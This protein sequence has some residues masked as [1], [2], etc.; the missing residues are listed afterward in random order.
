M[1]LP[2]FGKGKDVGRGAGGF[3]SELKKKMRAEFKAQREIEKAAKKAAK[4][5]RSQSEQL[6]ALSAA[7]WFDKFLAWRQNSPLVSDP[8]STFAGPRQDRFLVFDSQQGPVNQI[9]DALAQNDDEQKRLFGRKTL[10]TIDPTP[11]QDVPEKQALVQYLSAEFAKL[12]QLNERG[13]ALDPNELITWLTDTYGW[14][15]AA[16]VAL[17]YFATQHPT[18][19][20]LDDQA[21]Q[22][23]LTADQDHAAEQLGTGSVL[24]LIRENKRAIAAVTGVFTVPSLLA[25]TVVQ[26]YEQTRNIKGQVDHQLSLDV[27]NNQDRYSHDYQATGYEQLVK[28]DPVVQQEVKTLVQKYDLDQIKFIKIYGQASSEDRGLKN[29]ALKKRRAEQAKTAVVAMIEASAQAAGKHFDHPTLE[30]KITLVLD[31]SEQYKPGPLQ[32]PKTH[33]ELTKLAQ[34]MGYA[35]DLEMMRAYEHRP[36]KTGDHDPRW[37]ELR[38]YLTPQRGV[39]IEIATSVETVVPDRKEVAVVEEKI[40]YLDQKTVVVDPSRSRIEPGR[41]PRYRLTEQELKVDIDGNMVVYKALAKELVGFVKR[42]TTE[43]IDELTHRILRQWNELDMYKNLRHQLHVLATTQLRKDSPEISV[44]DLKHLFARAEARQAAHQ[45]I[46]TPPLDHFD[47]DQQYS[48]AYQHA[49]YML[50][51][52]EQFLG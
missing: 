48:Y 12:Q 45:I 25:G 51:H 24:Q 26:T 40:P 3:S 10:Q 34:R 41:D 33:A 39:H 52:R 31:E 42:P 32:N 20:P 50:A 16:A 13:L 44:A 11:G 49:E 28:D 29:E 23:Y 43:L 15:R 22:D 47:S 5:G 7:A 46:T 27:K 18:D 9:L 2:F 37:D 36:Q 14:Q 1:R 4:Q 38:T 17:V 6:A 35:S 30:K 19:Q 21:L 8:I